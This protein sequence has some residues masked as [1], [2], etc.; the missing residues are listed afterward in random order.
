M[1]IR[2]IVAMT[3]VALVMAAASAQAQIAATTT[4]IETTTTT[5]S[6]V[7]APAPRPAYDS[8]PAG[9]RRMA[10]TLYDA[11]VRTATGATAWSL[12]D[13]AAARSETGWGNVFKQM[14]A[15]GA[16]TQKNLGQ[17]V[18]GSHHVGATAGT[19]VVVTYGNGGASGSTTTVTR[20]DG[21]NGRGYAAGSVRQQASVTTA[22][23][24]GAATHGDGKGR[25]GK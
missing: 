7:A 17:L 22:A 12:D 13:V 8:L 20:H 21:G 18:S 11:Q 25:H 19:P 10:R 9:D 16:V 4:S 2:R 14:R 1:P 24:S 6:M 15:D 23:G 3:A 5:G